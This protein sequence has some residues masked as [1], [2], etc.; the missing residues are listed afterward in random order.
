MRRAIQTILTL[1]L[2]A[3]GGIAALAFA[4]P[5]AA[6][7]GG[8]VA[9]SAAAIAGFRVAVPDRLRDVIFIF[10]GLSM[11]AT[12]S[13]DTL[14][15]LGQWPIT[16]AALA[17]ELVVIVL[18]TGLMLIKVFRLDR[19]TAFLSSFPGHLSFVL[20][21]ASAGVGDP[22]Q[23]VIIQVTRVMMLTLC[24]PI[25]AMFL[26]MGTYAEA[27]G[28]EVMSLETLALMTAGCALAGYVLA[29]LRI[30]AAYV[31]GPMALATI[32]KLSGVFVGTMHPW[33]LNAVFIAMGAVIGA[34]FA[35]ITRA[36]FLNAALGAVLTTF[37]AVA[38]VTVFAYGLTGLVD[39]PFG[40]LWLGLS[41][42]GLEAMGALGIALGYDTA[43]IAAHHV[44]R[45][46]LLSLAIPAVVL[47]IRKLDAR[48]GSP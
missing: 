3:V 35:G 41:P 14:S 1:L 44:A 36:E 42:G 18:A 12:V 22:R 39:M 37:L 38:I 16:L 27:S 20:A 23:I 45:L 11:G 32:L 26:P 30:P 29:R 15:L 43:F 7:M 9:V 10:I 6:L 28:Q 25:G 17:L 8:A 40:Q 21:I 34:R 33:L 24:V 31:L 47:L 19:G 4:L 13:P 5:A 2:S 48:S 46:F